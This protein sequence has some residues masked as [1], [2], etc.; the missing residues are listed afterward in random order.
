MKILT[1]VTSM[2]KMP[3]FDEDMDIVSVDS[4][5]IH[6]LSFGDDDEVAQVRAEYL[7]K[8]CVDH[9]IHFAVVEDIVVANKLSAMDIDTAYTI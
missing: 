3:H 1:D 9:N 4:T 6:V 8:L 7:Y 2:D 5:D